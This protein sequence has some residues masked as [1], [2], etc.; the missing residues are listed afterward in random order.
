MNTAAWI[1]Q[2]VL[3]LVFLLHGLLYTV[4]AMGRSMEGQ[5]VRPLWFR[6]FIGVAEL[7]AAVGLTV[8]AL[9]H[10]ATWL[11]PL[12]GVGLVVVTLSA[13]VYHARRLEYAYVPAVVVLA[14]LAGFVAY[15]RVVSS[16]L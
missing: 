10:V 5:M 11:T 14:V 3:A 4:P 13:A 12:A 6:R 8:P 2:W 16:P 1:V 7:A 15:A 9:L